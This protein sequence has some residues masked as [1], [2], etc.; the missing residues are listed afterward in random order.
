MRSWLARMQYHWIFIFIL[1]FLIS[2][3]LLTPTWWAMGA[4]FYFVLKIFYHHANVWSTLAIAVFILLG[5]IWLQD[6]TPPI[7]PASHLNESASFQIR[8]DPLDLEQGPKGF[9]GWAQWVTREEE[10]IPVRLSYYLPQPSAKGNRSKMFLSPEAMSAASEDKED[11]SWLS[12]GPS[13]VTVTGRLK[14]PETARNFN[15]FDYRAYLANQGVYWELTVDR[16][17]AVRPLR[18]GVAALSR[19]RAFLLRPFLAHQDNALVNLHNKILYNLQSQT[20]RDTKPIFAA[21]GIL[22]FFAISGFHINWL[23][24]RLNYLLRRLGFWVEGIPPLII[25][26]LCFYGWLVAWPIGVIRAVSVYGLTY[27]NHRWQLKWSPMDCLA[28]SGSLVI[29][30]VPSMV[31]NLGFMLSYL[32]AGMLTFYPQREERSRLMPLKVTLVCFAFSW[33]LLIQTTYEWNSVQ[34]LVVLVFGLLF[35]KVIMPIAVFISIYLVVFPRGI[36][37]IDDLSAILETHSLSL[38]FLQSFRIYI[39]HLDDWKMVCLYLVAILFFYGFFTRPLRSL[40]MLVVAYLVLIGQTW[41]PAMQDRLT[42]IDV[43]QGDAT[44]YQAKGW[45][46]PWLIDTGGKLVWGD[47][48]GADN[49]LETEATFARTTIIPALKAAGVNTLEGIIVTHSDL[50]HLGNLA[51]VAATFKVKTVIISQPTSASLIWQ[52]IQARLPANVK[53]TVIKRPG[54]Y[55][56]G[57]EGMELLALPNDGVDEPN[58]QSLLVTGMVGQYRFMNMGDLPQERE[59][60]FLQTYPQL[61]ATI[62]KVGHHGSRTST[63]QDLIEQLQPRL[64][65]ISAGV[66]N[67]YHHPHKEV[68][69]RLT[70]DGVTYLATQTTGAIRVQ[71][72]FSGGLQVQTV[73]PS[74]DNLKQ[75]SS[76]KE[77]IVDINEEH[78]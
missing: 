26:I 72:S 9:R 45:T 77:R 20:Y 22:P 31:V 57:P 18:D 65:L 59:R 42:V 8:L 35:E 58:A 15:T 40:V 33:P 21:L 70:S 47:R 32:M 74:E 11:L 3:S 64:A 44:L 28:I 53:I 78:R 43:G 36:E 68:I 13:L 71:E 10:V 56:L 17:E 75:D 1:L 38:S 52:E 23:V 63:S 49:L 69:D 48:T 34:L 62:L 61:Q 16:I 25:T 7:V 19:L 73:L 67:P 46:H 12:A 14:K 4:L 30:L 27:L 54:R 2:T 6:R 41:L 37:V 51:E 55:P 24:T 66:N 5:Q 60:L 76:V 50:D 39:G 29:L